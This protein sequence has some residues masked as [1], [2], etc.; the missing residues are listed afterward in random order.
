MGIETAVLA[1]L[2][3][4]G[5]GTI[6]YKQYEMY[7]DLVCQFMAT[8]G[9]YYQNERLKNVQEGILSF[10]IRGIRYR[11]PL[12]DLCGIYGFERDFTEV[13]LPAHFPTVQD[14]WSLFRNG[15][16]DS[17]ASTQTDVR[18]PV[19]RYV[20]RLIGHTFL[21]KM[22]PGKMRVTEMV[23]LY[24]G[25]R[26]LIAGVFPKS[27]LDRPVNMGAVFAHHLVSLKTKP[28]TGKG[29]KI[30]SVGSLL[31]PIFR[32]FRID[33]ESC[34]IVTDCPVMDAEYMMHAQWMKKTLLWCF[35]DSRGAHLVQLPQA[36]LTDIGEDYHQL[37]FEPDPCDLVTQPTTRRRTPRAAPTPSE[38]F[39][40]TNSVG[41]KHR[42]SLSSALR[43]SF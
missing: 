33:L 11:L 12:R 24:F 35:S 32:H 30:E 43:L 28:F 14:F 34:R 19:L 9:V 15:Q 10:F 41:G 20:T 36:D 37:Q 2:D 1:L 6:A 39:T 21:C 13:V 3:K 31:T 8:V 38:E 25:L 17:K 27:K 26:D 16:C 4:I 23:L 7:P 29:K 5:L 22:E 42:A 18:H 40:T